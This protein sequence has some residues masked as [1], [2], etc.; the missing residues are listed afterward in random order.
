MKILTVTELEQLLDYEGRD[1][2]YMETTGCLHKG[3][4]ELVRQ[5]KKFGKKFLSIFIYFSAFY[6]K[7][8]G[9]EK[10]FDKD[11][12]L[13]ENVCDY[14]VIVPYDHSVKEAYEKHLNGFK[15]LDWDFCKHP[16]INL[17]SFKFFY[18]AGTMVLPYELNLWKSRFKINCEKN[19]LNYKL[20]RHIQSG[21]FPDFKFAPC[22]FFQTVGRNGVS[23]DSSDINCKSVE[24]KAE[25]SETIRWIKEQLPRD[26]TND[27]LLA[28]CSVPPDKLRVF[29]WSMNP[30]Q[31]VDTPSK[32]VP[33][34]FLTP[35]GEIEAS[36]LYI[37][38]TAGGVTYQA[39]YLFDTKGRMVFDDTTN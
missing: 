6:H 14:V 9:Y 11:C 35:M 32:C 29:Y 13:L 8:E 28:E 2:V 10:F 24:E 31:I 30:I 22:L 5:G 25:L 34:I 37:T 16:N 36:V 21:I 26:L 1:L 27:Q 18:T 33:D 7:T 17:E 19:A 4:V 20:V 15:L 39:Q 3:H 12:A 38:Y 23:Y